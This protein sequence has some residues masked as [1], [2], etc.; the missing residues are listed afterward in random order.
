MLGWSVATWFS[1]CSVAIFLFLF[2]LRPSRSVSMLLT[3]EP[4]F[5]LRQSPKR[6]SELR[7]CVAIFYFCF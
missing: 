6:K 3:V 7:R 5:M 2:S 1:L 4:L